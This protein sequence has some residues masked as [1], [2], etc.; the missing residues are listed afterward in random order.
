MHSPM[1]NMATAAFKRPIC[2]GSFACKQMDRAGARFLLSY[3]PTP[4]MSLPVKTWHVRE[5]TV[6]R[7]IAGFAK[8]RKD[9]TELLV[10]NY[11]Q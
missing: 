10:S 2:P 4:L 5:L 9:V 6:R 7:H 1:V 8:F 3:S 11:H